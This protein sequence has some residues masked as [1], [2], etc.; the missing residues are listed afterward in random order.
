MASTELEPTD[1][2]AAYRLAKSRAATSRSLAREKEDQ[3]PEARRA[4]CNPNDGL[5]RALLKDGARGG[6]CYRNK[7]PRTP[8]RIERTW[9][10]VERRRSKPRRRAERAAIE[11]LIP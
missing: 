1:G 8:G 6:T 5:V 9:R 11:T 4:R 10:Q 3:A 2:Y 7:L